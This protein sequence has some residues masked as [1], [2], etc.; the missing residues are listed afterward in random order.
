M[1]QRRA[2]VSIHQEVEDLVREEAAVREEGM[3]GNPVNAVSDCASVP[4]LR[5]SDP[6]ATEYP[7]LLVTEIDAAFT[8]TCAKWAP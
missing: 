6:F 2:I 7:D 3:A 4:P 5:D 1:P 8:A